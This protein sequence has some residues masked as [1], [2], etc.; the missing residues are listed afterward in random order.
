MNLTKLT[1]SNFRCFKELTIEFDPRLT[2][3]IATNGLGKTTVLDAIRIALWPYVRAFDVVS[4]TMPNSGIGIDDVRLHQLS[5]GNMEPQLPSVVS[6][7]A[8][9]GGQ[10]LAWSRKREK[11]SSGS[12]TS[13][14]DAK[15]IADAA[16]KLQSEIRMQSEDDAEESHADIQLPIIAHYGT[17]R[18]WKQRKL[19]LSKQN[20]SDVF[21]RTFAYMGCL[22]SASDYKSFSEWFFYIYAADFEQITKEFERSGYAGLSDEDT[23]YGKF[24]EAISSSVDLALKEQG[25]KGLRYSPTHQTIVMQHADFG[26]LKVDQLSDGLR[27]I[28]AMVADIA[29]RSV[30]LNPQL[31]EK[32]TDLTDGIVLIDEVDMHLHPSWQ[33]TIIGSLLDAFPK[34]QFILTTHSP[35]VITTVPDNCIRILGQDRSYVS[36]KGTKGAKASR[37]LKRVFGVDA[38]PPEDKYTKLLDNYLDLVYADQWN[39]PDA[40]AKRSK[41]DE[42]Y[43]DEEPALTKAD[44]YIENRIWELEIEKDQ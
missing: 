19:T 44:L 13:V 16:T 4:G 3:L 14:K 28:I 26:E 10:Q 8:D 21:S 9:Y 31:A 34:I 2:V 37:I 32:A 42:I 36:P 18:L 5:R 25:W 40:I 27:N 17:A 43:A 7:E 24:I 20:K 6:A 1:L 22:D 23:P 33:Q 29:Y 41:L 30:R 38:R 12:K 15:P 11:V 39:S 35:Q